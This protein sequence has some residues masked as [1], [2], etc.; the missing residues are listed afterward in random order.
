[1]RKHCQT[2]TH[3]QLKMWIYKWSYCPLATKNDGT[4]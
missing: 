4:L 2:A 1:M 3:A